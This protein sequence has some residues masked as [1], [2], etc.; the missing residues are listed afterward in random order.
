MEPEDLPWPG[1]LEEEE[2][3]AEAEAAVSASAKLDE[4]VVEEVEE[5]EEAAGRELDSDISYVY[6]L[7]E[8]SDEDE[9]EEAKAWLQAHPGGTLPT[10]VHLT[11]HRTSEGERPC[12]ERT[13][14][15][16]FLPQEMDS[17]QTLATS[18][19]KFSLTTEGADVTD[20]P[21]VEEG[22][23]TQSDNQVRDPNRDLLCSPLLV[24]QDSFATPDLPLLTCSTQD[25]DFGPDSLFH[26]SELGFAPLRGIPDRSEDTEWLSRPSEVSEA[27]FQATSDVASDLSNSCFSVSQHT[28]IGSTATGS[29]RSFMPPEQGDDEEVVSSCSAEELKTPKDSDSYCAPYSCMSWKTRKDTQQPEINLSEKDDVSVSISSDIPDAN[30]DS[31]RS[32]DFDASCSYAQYWKQEAETYLASKEHDSFLDLCDTSDKNKIPK[33][34]NDFCVP[35][36]CVPQTK[37]GTPQNPETCAISKDCV[38]FPQEVTPHQNNTKSKAYSFLRS[39]FERRGKGVPLTPDSPYSQTVCLR[40]PVENEVRQ[41]MDCLEGYERNEEGL[42]EEL[43]Q[44]FE[45][46]ETENNVSSEVDPISQI[47]YV[48]KVVVPVNSTK[49]S[50]AHILSR[51]QDT[52]KMEP[53]A[54]PLKTIKSNLDGTSKQLCFQE[55]GKQK[56]TS[57]FGEKNVDATENIAFEAII[58]SIEPSKKESTVNEIQTDINKSLTD[59]SKE[60]EQKN[61][62]LSPLNYNDENSFFDKLKHPRY[63]STPGVFEP[64]TSEPLLPKKDDDSS[65]YRHLNLKSPPNAPQEMFIKPLFVIPEL[66]SS[67]SLNEKSYKQAVGL[68]KTQ[69]ALFQCDINSEPFLP[70]G[71]I[72]SVPALALAEKVGSSN[73]I[74]HMKLSTSDS[75]VLQDLKQPTFEEVADSSYYELVGQESLLKADIGQ[76]EIP[77]L[78]GAEPSFNIHSVIQNDSCF[79]GDLQEKAESD[80]IALDA[81]RESFYEN[82]VVLREGAAELRRRA[83][84]SYLGNQPFSSLMPSFLPHESTEESG[85]QS[86]TLRM[87]RV[88]PDTLLKTLQHL[89][90]DSSKGGIAYITQSNLKSG[91]T[92]TTGDSDSVSHLSLSP[93]DLSQLAVS[94]EENVIGQHTDT[95]NQK[96]LADTCLTEESLK[97]SA[98]PEP[99][100]SKTRTP[101]VPSS[102]YLH[103]GKPSIFYQSG[104]SKSHLTEEV[105]KVT[106]VSGPAGTPSVASTSYSLRPK[107]GTF[108]QQVLTGSQIPEDAQKVSPVLGSAD[109]PT[110]ASTFYSR[111]KPSIFYQQ[112]LPHSNLIEDPL[113]VSFAPEFADQ[114][115]GKNTV[116]SSSYSHGEKPFSFYQQ[117]LP[118][119]HLTNQALKVSAVSGPANQKTGIAPVPST[120]YSQKERPST[121]Y[122]PELPDIHETEEIL[123]ITDFNEPYDHK[124]EIP[125]V[126]PSSYTQR[127]K[128]GLLY[129][130][131]LPSSLLPEQG[132]KTSGILRSAEQKTGTPI[133]PSSSYSQREKPIVF[134]QQAVPD[135]HLTEETRKG[136]AVTRQADQKTGVSTVTSA[137]YSQAENPI[138]CYPQSLPDGQLTEEARKDSAV[139]RLAEQ[140]TG[141]STVTSAPYSQ[142]GK[143]IV[144]YQQNLPD[145]H[146]TEEA[147][148]GS[149]V[150]RVTEQKTGISTVTS[151]PYSQAENPIVCYP[152]SFPDGC[153]TEEARKGSA[154]ARVAEQKTG[155]ST[156]T[157]APYSQAENPIVC[158]PQSLPDGR[159]T[160]EA[161]KGLAVARLAEQKTGVP[162]VTSA[163]YSQAENPIVCYPQS[164]PDSCLTEEAQKGSTV[165]RLAEQKTGISTVTS[166]PY[167]Q[168][169][170]PIVCYPQS[171]PDGRLT[172]EAWKGSAVARLAD[173]KTGISTVTCAPYSQTENPIVCYPQSLPDGRL[174]EEALKGLAVAR[175]A[176]QKTGI[177]TVTSAP[178]S[179]AENP[180]VCYPQSLPDGRL[181]EEARKGLAVAR[182]AEQKTGISTVTSATYSQA[183][184]TIV[185]YPQSLAGSCLTE[186]ARKSSAAARLAE[187]RT[188]I[189]TVTSAP[190]SQAENPIVFYQQNLPDSHLTEEAQKGSTVARLA[191]QKTGISTVTSA[192]YTQAEKKLSVYYQQNL[193]DS[194]LTEEG[195]KGSAVARLAEQK[196]GI[197]TVT[198]APY[199]QA[200]NP[201][202]F[203]Q[204]SLP[205]SHLT[206]EARKGSAAARL[207]DQKTGVST[208]TSVPYSQAENPIVCYPQSLPDS[209][210]TVEAQ[211][212]SAVAR[213]A[214]QKTGVSTVTSAPYSQAGKPIVFYPQSLPDSHLTEEAQKSSAA[215]RLAE[216]KTGIS[217][218]TSAPY[219]QAENPIVFYPQSLPDGHLTEEAWKG[220]AVARLADQKTGVSI[221]TS[222]PYSQ[223]EN[224]IVCYPQSLPDG[225]LTEEAL[226]GLAVA[227][228]AEQKT[229]I[230][231]V[232]SAPY[233]QAENP[234]VCYPQSLPDSHLTEEA[235]KSST[236]ARLAEQKTGISTI[237]SAPYSQTE[238]PIVCYPQSLPDGRLTEEARKGLAV[239]R[240]AEQKTR[241]STVTSAPYSQAENPIVCYP[242]SLPDGHLTEEAQKS[243]TVAR[244]A[245]QKTGISTVTSAS[246]TQA[247]K[248]L[249]VFYQQN[250]PDSRLTAEAQKGSTVAR[251][252]EQN[253]GISTVTSAS[254]TQ[255]EK[256]L[257]VFY[258]QNLPDSCLTAEALKGSAVARLA[259][260]KTGISTV[261]SVPYSQGE[262]K[263]SVFHPPTLP[264]SY[265]TE[266]GP[267]GSAVARLADQKTG[268]S[269]VTSAPYS[270]GEKLLS[271]FYLQSLPDSHLTEEGL[272][273]SVFPGPE[274]KTELTSELSSFYSPR[275]KSIIV[276]QQTLPNSHLPEE[277]L[278]VSVVSGPADQKAGKRTVSFSSNLAREKSDIFCPQELPDSHPPKEALKVS[279]PGLADLNTGTPTVTSGSYSY[280]DTSGIFYQQELS[281]SHSTKKA[282]KVSVVPEPA[283]QKTGTQ[284]INTVTSYSQREKPSIFY[285]QALPDSHL[286]EEALKISGAP[287]PADQTTGTP[288]GTSASFLQYREKP[289]VF[290]QQ[291][292]FSSHL[293]EEAQKVSPALGSADQKTDIPTTTSTY[294]Q[295]EKPIILYQQTLP[296]SHLTQEAQK[297]ALVSGPADQKSGTLTAP[298]TFYSQI[299]K[300]IILYQQTLPDSHPTQEAQ[301]VALVSG[302]ANQKSGILTVP[303]TSYLRREK[304]GIFH[305]EALTGSY[306]TEEAQ[307]ISA[308]PE[309]ADQKTGTPIVSSSSYSLG[310]KPIIFFQRVLSDSP[311]TEEGLEVSVVSGPADQK[312]RIPTVSSV[313]YP[314]GGKPIIFYQQAL[315][316]GKLTKEAL[317]VLGV[318]GPVDQ[319][320]GTSTVTYSHPQREKSIISYQQ[321][322][323][324]SNLTNKALKVSNFPELTDQKT[325]IP[326]ITSSSFSLREKSSNSYE[327]LSEFDEETLILLGLASAAD[328]KSLIRLASSSSYSHSEKPIISYQEELPEEALKVLVVPG[329]ADQKTGIQI[330]PSTSYSQREQPIISYESELPGLTEGSLKAGGASRPA[331]QKTGVPITSSSSYSKGKKPSIFHQQKLPDN[332]EEA[333]DVFV[334]PGSGSQK[335]GAPTVPFSSCSHRTK[336]SVYSQQEF[337]DSLPTDKPLKVSPVFV[338]VE[339][340][341]ARST[342]ISNSYSHKETFKVSSVDVLDDHKTELSTGTTSSYSDGEKLSI[343]TLIGSDDQKSPSLAVFPSSYSPRVKPGILLQRQLPDRDQSEDIVK[344]SAVPAPTDINTK[345][346]VTLSSSYFHRE[347]SNILYPQ[348]FPDRHLIENALKVSTVPGP[349]DQ[350]TILSVAPPSSF[351][352]SEKSGIFYQKDLP[353]RHVTKD[354]LKFSSGPGQADQIT[355][356]Q[357]VPSG[358]K[359]KL[360][361]KPVQRPV[362]KSNS[363]DSSVSLNNILLYSQADDKVIISKSESSG[364][365]DVGSEEI[366]DTESSSRTLKEIQTLLMEAENIALKR[367]NFPAPLVPFR[368]VGDISF[369][370]SKKVVCFKEPSTTDVSSDLVQRQ[371]FTEESPNNRSMQKD[372]GTQTS[373]KSQ[374]GIENWEFISSTTVRSPLQEAEHKAHVALEETFRQYEAA[375]CVMRTEPEG[376]SG[377]IGNKIIIPM[378]TII[379]DSSSDVSD[380]NGSCSWD[381]NLPESLESVSDVL[382]NFFPY[383]SPK[384]SI[385]DSREEE[386]MSESED[387]AGSSVDSLAAH[388]KNLLKCES[389]LNHA[390]QILRNAEEE[391]CR[392]R[393]RAWNLKFNLAQDCGYS[394]SELNEDD[395]RKVEEIKAE[396][397]G[398]GRTTDLS[399]GLQSPRGIGSNPEAVCSH[400]IIESHEKGCFRT[401]T[402]EQPQL[403]GHTC[404]FRSADPSEMIRGRRSPSSWK[405]RHINLS[406]SLDQNNP[407]FKVWNSLQLQSHSPLQDFVSDDFKISKGLRMPFHEKMNPWLPELVEPAFVPP[408]EVDFHS[409]S[410]MPPLE[411]TTQFTTSITFSSHRHSKCIS[412]SSI[413]KVGVTEGSQC[414]G[415]SVGVFKSHFTEEQNPPR[416]LNQKASSPSSFKMCSHSPDKYGTILGEG[417]RKSQKLPVDF[418][419]SHQEEKLL[420]RSDFKGSHSEPSTSANGS[421][422]KEIQFSNNH[423]LISMSRP[424]STLEIKEKNV[425]ITPDLSSCIF[426]EQKELSEQ[427]KASYADHHVRKHHFSPPQHQDH[428]APIFSSCI[429]L[430]QRELYEQSTAPHVDYHMR[431][432]YS[433][434]PQ[435]QDY[436]ASDLPSH[437]FLEHQGKAPGIDDHMREHNLPLPQGQDS[438]VEKNNQHKPK[439]HISNTVNVETKFNNVSQLAPNHGTLTTSASTPPSSRK[440]LSCVRITLCPKTPSKLDSGTLGKRFHSLDAASKTRMDSEFNF[441]LQTVSSRSLE[442]TSRLLTSKPIAQDQESLGFLG[443]KS[444][445]DFHVL[446]SSLPDSNTVT[447]DLKIIPSQNRQIVTSKQIQVN[448]SDLEGFSNPEETPISADRSSEKSKKIKTSF[449]AFPEKLSS[450]AVTQIT[451]EGPEKTMFSSEI[452]I[453]AEDGGHEIP[454][455]RSQ[456][457]N[458]ASVKLTPPSLVQQTTFSS[459]TDGQPSLLPYKPSGSTKM[460]YVP[461]LGQIPASLDSKS[462]TTL[463]SSHSDLLRGHHM[464]K[465]AFNSALHHKRAVAKA[466]LPMEK[467]H[468]QNDNADA[469]VQ[470]SITGDKN[471][472]D[473]K[474]KEEIYST[475]AVTK[476]AQPEEKESLQKDTAGSSLIPAAVPSTQVK[477]T[478]IENL[479]DTKST[480][481]KEETHS[482]V[483]VPVE[484]WTENK[485]SLPLDIEESEGHSEFENTTHSVFKSANFYIHHPVHLPTDQDISHESLG[486][487]V[488]MGRSLKDFFQKHPDKHK[489]H[490]C[491]LPSYQN[492]D[493]TKTDYTRVKSLSINGNLGNKEVIHTTKSQAKDHPQYSR[494]ISDPKRD[495]KVTPELGTL[496]TKSL[497]ELWNKYLERQKQQK[498]PELSD[499]KELSLVERLDRLARLLQNPITH[500]L[501]ASESTHDD[502]RGEPG[503]KEWSGKQQRN[504]LQKKKRYKSLEKSRKIT[505]DLKKSKALSAHVAGK[506]NQI[507][508]EQV[509]FDKYI[510]RKQ[511]GFNYK[512]NTSSD[513]RTSEESEVLT[514]TPTNVLSS[515]TSAESDILTQTDREIALHERSSSISTIDTARLIHAFGQER[516]CLSPRQVKLYSS[517]TNQQRRFLEKRC[518]HS[519]KALNIGHPLMTSEYS[520][521]RRIQ[522]PDHMISSDSVSSS[523]GTFLSS[524]STLC[525]KRNVHMLNKG[526]QAGNL[527]IVNGATNHTRDVGMTFPTPSPSEARLEENSDVTSWLE[528]KNEEKVPL[529]NY[530]EDK[531]LKKNKQTFCEG[532]SWF[533]PVE[534]VKSESK[535]ENLPKI[536]GPSISWFEPV[537]KTKPWREPLR[538]Q[539]W[540]GQHM[541]GGGSLADP[542]RGDGR[543]ALKSLVRATL[544]ESLQLHRPDFIS[545]SGERIKRLRLIVQERKLQNIFQSEREALFNTEWQSSRNPTHLLPKRIFLATQKYRPIGKKEMIQ[546]SKR[547]YE[548]L[549]EVKK[550]REEEKR[551]SE[552]KSYRL[553]AQLYKKKVTNQLLGRKVPWD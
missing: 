324:D 279:V 117:T 509:K 310:E 32:D 166:A 150:A 357:T 142:A 393:A 160:E 165:A 525:N 549:P 87:L 126:Y 309:P 246:Y 299:E 253:T 265:L 83:T 274:Q 36:S 10:P 75:L 315:S 78:L 156:V 54:G 384:T 111:E 224:P 199:S 214:D 17:S 59:N 217:T 375:K 453:N 346:A 369:I 332:T 257:S 342:G 184:N 104:L 451:T 242:Q 308:A 470:V 267:K 278:K 226:K 312:T 244:L 398:H 421:N 46:T 501:Q 431:E 188:G 450:D 203:Y 456:K 292:L 472:S 21:S 266:E 121:F 436:V 523:P 182:L 63:E 51:G 52:F 216:Q 26:Q 348:E 132:L 351:S 171:L 281:D 190:Y 326:T 213:L 480:K 230:S 158:Y 328:R 531:N 169:E 435:G 394:I 275:E 500:S 88:S 134:Y 492:V 50:E 89:T 446:Q 354:A 243:S 234:I 287:G 238:N 415:A 239:A 442:P 433:P 79:V 289:G 14:P 445:L 60:R 128:P 443:P 109:I 8:S 314:L 201:I 425:T 503:V 107:L 475:R 396:L 353:D 313:S 194:C 317:K 296:D 544:Q 416:D 345:K 411:P 464:I 196:T 123:K 220:S 72:K 76:G 522:V 305:Q 187:Q 381:S 259:E 82:D 550:K 551:R 262:K 11:R 168:A 280:R 388:V 423:T 440:A 210:L 245:E 209:H 180:I 460:Y 5:A 473:K 404:V 331:D 419:H 47:Q 349:V 192:S 204:Q 108:Q 468:L 16:H 207:A 131:V 85:Y 452:F 438:V 22:L 483:T 252:A 119:S 339:Q 533:V 485:E 471:L 235:Q 427:N 414:T 410:Q 521:R 515:P 360:V 179:Q 69:S 255:A 247:E 97:I 362:N 434:L 449:S 422:F 395:R 526:V 112:E 508:I 15:W 57:V 455:P 138:V 493:K 73:I 251:L 159:L 514:D 297:V 320:T 365:A 479:P 548:Q 181:T 458:K 62:D 447:Q 387:C 175:L 105:L 498:P 542:V 356:L 249:S 20:F 222:A 286:T 99:T 327:D 67:A 374:R 197:S 44:C 86:P 45:Q 516:V 19:T 40:A 153:L 185:F 148:K 61:S 378:M 98:T 9:D 406:T 71:E 532:V 546:R 465:V 389:S 364:L 268:I 437:I 56:E 377:T 376:C 552:Y 505:G 355:E 164:L 352:H 304:P 397:F 476:A 215:V 524:N 517:V 114:K 149:A 258:Q 367:C 58:A 48:G 504:K 147:R 103:S 154:V 219:S 240:L 457:R 7:L 80:T 466:S 363:S 53:S 65:L 341:T 133:V 444:P 424:S 233:S 3:E 152:Q 263:L 527:E 13:D 379:S 535:K 336:P 350:R 409:S 282:L 391:E 512:S 335:T 329:T 270:E 284:A 135:S 383:V 340:K 256:K 448:I 543:D 536:Y 30:I 173:Q 528:E 28:L 366:R 221:V 177:S 25:Q 144:F 405:D 538:E 400:I 307:K 186:E 291:N 285:Q 370:Q 129:Q 101:P 33:E 288:A 206:E 426:L 261:T 412:D 227:R 176:E 124:T 49:V 145:R 518:K 106:G 429:F 211:K 347:K 1:E 300:P 497:N 432:K 191:E 474:Q 506:S 325:G 316:D 39:M 269:S 223:A 139:A 502:S 487:S 37:E 477:D 140:K 539:N 392:V 115:T 318:A 295:R 283:D 484:A 402:A 467:K 64:A 96:T 250:L 540:Q 513:S 276:S 92:T 272:K 136:S 321:E 519:R 382:L 333:I 385:T 417:S 439:S 167:S 298:S 254:Y 306:L 29:Q 6:Q 100:Y 302:P 462:D 157:S 495:H 271:I 469:Q 337:P 237:T 534:N 273:G 401:L 42:Q 77:W 43:S 162:T 116:F 113:R 418:E 41:K 143:P 322:L 441:D 95:F 34:S 195:P 507:K 130:P 198:S 84:H 70:T 293:L 174:T 461:Q 74:Y 208:A 264:D 413:L 110:I 530:P 90:G 248:K 491:F 478:K 463:E 260:Q 35:L 303:S 361:S 420:E 489:E 241:V 66:K 225:R 511:P 547:I 205:D 277:A 172:E 390:K 494:Q 91:I 499:K 4:I 358:E 2:E 408:K 202:V 368:D 38:C 183:E 343:S 486:K 24:I 553:R 146:L 12:R 490:S 170:N 373:L 454:E 118:E 372:I 537:T 334:L 141:I 386:G 232:T 94:S 459:G 137:P 290:Y 236:V 428:I 380:G 399:K 193:T 163:P 510:L 488:F 323:L 407:R 228:L 120:F 481:Q 344:I 68:D 338:P 18:Q 81:A 430:E 301:K 151:A 200:E 127:E 496:P 178:Y 229:G 529:T 294:S 545:R 125:A 55:E 359:H 189:S 27:L 93:E 231:T 319:K 403:D 122:K 330:V 102:S 371:L 218:V 311:L 482:K 212:G 23:L 31:K 161:R 541:D 520:R 155:I